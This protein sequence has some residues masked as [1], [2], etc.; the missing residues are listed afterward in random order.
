MSKNSASYRNLFSSKGKMA[1]ITR[2]LLVY[3]ANRST[4]DMVRPTLEPEFTSDFVDNAADAKAFL[5]NKAVHYD[6]F[7]M[8]G[9]VKSK[10]REFLTQYAREQRPGIAVINTLPGVARM[11]IERA[12]AAKV[13]ED[14]TSRADL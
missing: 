3:G 11:Q 4:H 9:A 7:C 13:K 6:G 8:G 14:S 10:D 12:F 1:A 2:H 5:G